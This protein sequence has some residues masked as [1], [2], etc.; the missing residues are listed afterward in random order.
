MSLT[1]RVA[2]RKGYSY[3]RWSYYGLFLNVFALV[4]ASFKKPK[5]PREPRPA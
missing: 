2:A 1:A 5:Q 4:L 3:T